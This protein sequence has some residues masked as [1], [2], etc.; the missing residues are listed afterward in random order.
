MKLAIQLN[1]IMARKL[2]KKPPIED[3]NNS[4]SSYALFMLIAG[5]ITFSP[6]YSPAADA[7]EKKEERFAT[8]E[9]EIGKSCLVLSLSFIHH[10]HHHHKIS[11]SCPD[12]ISL[13]WR[14]NGNFYVNAD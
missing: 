10:H 1:K 13:R 4:S 6:I 8:G 9:G 12:S 11:Q 5:V 3:K 7:E 14:I 2:E